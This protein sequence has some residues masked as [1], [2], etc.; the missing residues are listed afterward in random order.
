[1]TKILRFADNKEPFDCPDCS[2]IEEILCL[3]VETSPPV[4]LFP[5]WENVS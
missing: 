5:H 4:Y 1:M 3:P 2:L